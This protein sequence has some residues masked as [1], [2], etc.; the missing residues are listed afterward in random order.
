MMRVSA[1][2]VSHNSHQVLSSCLDALERQTVVVSEVIVVDCGSTDRG[3]LL[4]V[5]GRKGVKVI[6]TANIGFSQANNLGMELVSPQTD[7]V[8]YLNPDTFLFPDFVDAA[9]ALCQDNPGVGMMS[10]KL[11]GYDFEKNEPTGRLDS[12]G[13]FQRWYGRWYD[14]GQGE[15]DCGQ[16]ETPAFPPALCG[17]LLFCRMS[18][19]Q[20]LAG[21]VFDPDF[22]LYKED[23]E[24]S[25]RLRKAGWQLLYHPR[26]LAYH[27]RGW[28]QERARMALEIRRMAAE[29]EILLYRKHPSVF[30]IWACCKYL[31][32]RI[33]H[34]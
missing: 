11:C 16:Y 30:M 2:I 9:L 8:L 29:N 15:E 22:F 19:L 18:A 34:L 7:F 20:E 1:I 14:R 10:G 3:Y 6:E 24:L 28:K 13:V 21:P 33:F 31:L 26:L 23:I 17:A 12:T 4:P 5:R 27:C 32:V 25:L